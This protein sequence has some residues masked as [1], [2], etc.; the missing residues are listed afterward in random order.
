MYDTVTQHLYTLESDHHCKSSN[1]LSKY[2]VIT[3]LLESQFSQWEEL[4][5][6]KA[7]TVYITKTYQKLLEM[8]WHAD[9]EAGEREIQ[10]NT[11]SSGN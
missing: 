6:L 1:H 10:Q 5:F 8:G 4:N 2:N 7:A 11:I 9:K 3:I